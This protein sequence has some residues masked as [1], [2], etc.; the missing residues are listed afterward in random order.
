MKPS[1]KMLV[2]SGDNPT[3]YDE[4]L[5]SKVN[6]EASAGYV[7]TIYARISDFEQLSKAQ[8]LE[9]RERRL[10][11][12]SEDESGNCVVVYLNKVNE[13][14]YFMTSKLIRQNTTSIEQ[15]HVPISEASYNHLSRISSNNI[16]FERHKFPAPNT[17]VEW[18][19]DVFKGA[20][21]QRHN[22]VKIDIE[23]A[24]MDS[25]V[26]ALPIVC[27]EYFLDFPG[28][29]TA[30]Q[31]AFVAKLWRSQWL[32]L[33]SEWVRSRVDFKENNMIGTI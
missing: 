8:T 20:N 17:D 15:V 4:K 27:E 33:D 18:E 11:T 24:D 22:W 23:V 14:G 3:L 32:S 31:K 10:L 30:D 2:R 12:N 6:G 1:F 26:P 28:I 13:A 7:F 19:V 25:D 5:V 29:V 21:G 16:P 9:R